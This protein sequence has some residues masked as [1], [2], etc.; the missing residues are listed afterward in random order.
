MHSPPSQLPHVPIEPVSSSI[1]LPYGGPP[2]PT[3]VAEL[4]GKAGAISCHCKAQCTGRR[5]CL[6]NQFKCSLPF[7]QKLLRNPPVRD[8]RAEVVHRHHRCR[9]GS[10][11]G[12]RPSASEVEADNR[13]G[14]RRKR[15]RAPTTSEPSNCS[16]DQ[17]GPELTPTVL[18][19][20]RETRPGGRSR[21]HP[22]MRRRGEG[23][24][25][26]G[27]CGGNRAPPPKG[28]GGGGRARGDG[29]MGVGQARPSNAPFPL[30]GECI[31]F[32]LFFGGLGRMR[33]PTLTAGHHE[34]SQNFVGRGWGLGKPRKIPPEISR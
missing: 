10:Q 32:V 30:S 11:R 29:E 24:G 31:S 6:K 28:G 34:A 4:A 1:E 9:L 19:L 18:T 15:A 5:R 13:H 12:A 22:R 3:S 7:R 20:L 14:V 33:S 26:R 16:G 8:V 17:S 21:W 25:G 2:L 23:G 27:G